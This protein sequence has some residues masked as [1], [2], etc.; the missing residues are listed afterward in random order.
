MSSTRVMPLCLALLGTLGVLI[1]SAEPRREAIMAELLIQ[2]QQEEA[3]FSGFSAERGAAFYQ[4]THQGGKPGS[5]ACTACHGND[6]H[7]RGQTR[8][9]KA[10]EPMAVSKQPA[11]YTEKATV[12]KW[13]T[14]NCQD[15]LGRACTAREKGDFLTYMIGQ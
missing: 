3:G 4:A 2:A 14:R 11:R 12:E 15:V 8:A 13:F 1:A 7:E 9:G 5:N 10:I 6:P